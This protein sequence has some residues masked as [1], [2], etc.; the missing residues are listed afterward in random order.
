MC[1]APQGCQARDRD[2]KEW[3]M[4]AFNSATFVVDNNGVSLQFSNG[5]DYRYSLYIVVTC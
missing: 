1:A 5:D 4:G 3:S 2:D